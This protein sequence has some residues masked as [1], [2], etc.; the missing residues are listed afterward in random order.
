MEAVRQLKVF[1]PPI[2]LGEVSKLERLNWKSLHSVSNW[3]S[4]SSLKGGV[5][6]SVEDLRKEIRLQSKWTEF[7]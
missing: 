7:L 3:V 5:K 2:D 6:E 4:V 1:I